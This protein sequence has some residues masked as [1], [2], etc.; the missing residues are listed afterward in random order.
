M[1]DDVAIELTMAVLQYF[2]NKPTE[3]HLFRTMKALSK[4]VTVSGLTDCGHSSVPMDTDQCFKMFVRQVSPDIPQLVQMIGPHPST[5]KGTSDRID[6][7][8]AQIS[9]KVR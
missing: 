7:L 5:F 2:Q 1:F 8:I 3:E 9:K 4:F 6:E